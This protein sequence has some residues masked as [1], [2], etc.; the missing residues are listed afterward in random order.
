MQIR[1][2]GAAAAQKRGQSALSDVLDVATGKKRTIQAKQRGNRLQ[3]EANLQRPADE[4]KPVQ[5]LCLVSDKLA[6]PGHPARLGQQSSG[7]VLPKGFLVDTGC[8]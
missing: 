5:V 2:R 4:A 1:W 3:G 6:P 8:T 7:L